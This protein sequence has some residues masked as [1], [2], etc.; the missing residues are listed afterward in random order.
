MAKGVLGK[1]YDTGATIVRQ[2]DPGDV[3][4]VI[5][6]GQV[7]VVNEKDAREVRLAV[8]KEGD[9]F[10]EVP[11]FERKNQIGVVRA[12]VRALESVRVL[13]VD[14]KTLVRRLHEDPSLSYR[15][16]QT[17]ARRVQEMEEEIT[18]LIIEG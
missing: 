9:F 2:G 7:E 8:L 13:T 4:Y 12:T 11:F 14:K 3:M 6:E 1:E 5:Q 10:G 18:R 16:L 15:I 17:M